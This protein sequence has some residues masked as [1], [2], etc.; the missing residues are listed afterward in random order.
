[1]KAGRWSLTI[2]APSMNFSG[3][4]GG[5]SE[6]LQFQ[7]DGDV[8]VTSAKTGCIDRRGSQTG[9]R[10]RATKTPGGV[11][12]KAVREPCGDHAFVMTSATWRAR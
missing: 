10:Y 9:G 12:F 8:V 1:M 7:M 6:S 4:G 2:A 11:R 3:P 5:D